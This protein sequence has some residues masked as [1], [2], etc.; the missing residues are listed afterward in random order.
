MEPIKPKI[1]LSLI[2]ALAL[3]IL[4]SCGGGGGAGNNN[5]PPPPPPAAKLYVSGVTNTLDGQIG[6]YS[7]ATF[8][9]GTLA[10][11]RSISGTNTKLTAPSNSG[12]REIALD[13]TNDRLY[14]V[15][16]STNSILVFDG[17]SQANGN[18]A[19]AREITGTNTLLDAPMSIYLDN[20]NNRLYVSNFGTTHTVLVFDNASSITGNVA[21]TR[22]ISGFALKAYSQLFGIQVDTVRN[23]LYVADANYG[24]LYILD[25]AS[26]LNGSVSASRVITGMSTNLS[27][28]RALALDSSGNRIYVSSITGTG[29]ILVFDNASSATGDIAP[30]RSIST[31]DPLFDVTGLFLDT[32]HD[33]LYALNAS[34]RKLEYFDSASSASGTL[35]PTVTGNMSDMIPFGIFVDTR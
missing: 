35:T 21:P 17:A 18:V 26:T 33:R 8:A 12:V 2:S 15:N 32:T 22:V 6:T 9:S 29:A 4:S 23:I 34:Y 10:A 19:P 1:I 28:A 27:L 3:L 13:V 25:N 5:P 24:A 30:N 11:S 14:A 20:T 7:N 16:L 31:A